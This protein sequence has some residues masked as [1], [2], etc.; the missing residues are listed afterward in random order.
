MQSTAKSEQRRRRKWICRAGLPGC[1]IYL[2]LLADVPKLWDSAIAGRKSKI[3][4]ICCQPISTWYAFCRGLL[5]CDVLDCHQRRALYCLAQDE[6]IV[7]KLDVGCSIRRCQVVVSRVTSLL[8]CQPNSF[9]QCHTLRALTCIAA[10]ND[11][12]P[13]SLL[14]SCSGHGHEWNW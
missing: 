9:R 3:C 6:A 14:T 5:T 8:S 4:L 7:S 12:H 2:G 1:R 11:H 10:H 13:L